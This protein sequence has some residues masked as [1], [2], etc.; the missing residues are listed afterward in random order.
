MKRIFLLMMFV[1][2]VS[3]ASKAAEGVEREILLQFVETMDLAERFMSEARRESSETVNSPIEYQKMI[4]DVNQI[5]TAVRRHVIAPATKPHKLESLY[6]SYK[7]IPGD[8]ESEKL[9]QVLSVLDVARRQAIEAAGV[10]SGNG[11]VMLRYEKLLWDVS[12]VS[13]AVS[14]ILTKPN[15]EPRKVEEL[16]ME[17]KG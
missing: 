13:A 11:R 7:L 8:L 10:S 15:R 14:K 3:F 5:A 9:G 4:S 17:Y 16:Y 2:V 6:L 1:A 12:E